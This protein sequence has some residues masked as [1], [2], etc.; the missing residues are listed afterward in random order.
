M[1]RIMKSH[2]FNEPALD[3]QLAQQLER[4]SH[5]LK[6]FPEKFT[7]PAQTRARAKVR[8]RWLPTARKWISAGHLAARNL[9]YP[10][11]NWLPL[12]T[13]VVTCALAQRQLMVNSKQQRKTKYDTKC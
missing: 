6:R 12:S 2:S 8:W 1:S 4:A 13:R 9:G 3:H 7:P 5:W 11:P 10:S